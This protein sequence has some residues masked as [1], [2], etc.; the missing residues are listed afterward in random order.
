MEELLVPG[1]SDQDVYERSRRIG[2]LDLDAVFRS[3][4]LI[5]GAGALGNEI[6]RAH[7]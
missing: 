4:V 5:V 3:R 6:G 7:V 1:A 2:W